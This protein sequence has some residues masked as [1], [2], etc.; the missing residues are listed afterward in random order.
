LPGHTPEE[1]LI[2]AL[3]RAQEQSQ[4]LLAVELFL[5][6]LDRRPERSVDDQVV[7]A[8]TAVASHLSEEAL[9]DL[10]SRPHSEVALLW[11]RRLIWCRPDGEAWRSYE[12]AANRLRFLGGSNV[13]EHPG[14]NER[15]SP[16]DLEDFKALVLA[17]VMLD[18]ATTEFH[19]AAQALDIV[20]RHASPEQSNAML[21]AA[22]DL[23]KQRQ[24]DLPFDNQEQFVKRLVRF[25]SLQ[26]FA[27]E[28]GIL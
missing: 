15:L 22:M 13:F 26:P 27:K 24:S 28:L 8:V 21:T 18:P 2:H 17:A 23:L 19:L 16:A 6:L 14:K 9:K 25:K 7:E 5:R 4:G 3:A 1:Q 20:H 12:A 11:V 10:A